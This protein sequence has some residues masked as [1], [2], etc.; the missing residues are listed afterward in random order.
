MININKVDIKKRSNM[1]KILQYKEL[2]LLMLPGILF[3]FI[4][5]YLPMFGLVIAFQDY[6]PS[7]GVNGIFSADF[8]GLKHFKVFFNSIYAK[9]IIS[10]TLIISFMKLVIGF[11]APIIL[12][13]MLNEVR[14]KHFK[15]I[16]QT[17]TYFPHF[18]SWVIVGGM[19]YA[20]L[21]TTSGVINNLIV[22]MGNEP[23]NFLSNP[24]TFRML[25]VISDTWK[26]IGWGSIIYLA[27]LAGISPELYE[28]AM[29]DGANKIQRLW[30]ITLP[31][32]TSTIIVVLILRLG[33]MMDIG[34]EQ[35]FMLYNPMVYKVGD[36][37]D[38]YV[39]R[40]GLINGRF[41]YAAA[42]GLFKSFVS[43]SAVLISDK[44][45]KK[46]GHDGII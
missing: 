33:K 45:A 29:I 36:I 22:S 43:L 46:V 12:A 15:K 44:L 17:V 35:I 4:F 27:A 30:Y 24:K 40:E 31:S 11:P 42:V 28:S 23:V 20:M 26:E 19:M 34:F 13:L 39:Y 7:Q 41:S 8:V 5:K 37:I 10:N 21:S 3:F 25:I 32:I 9:Q 38:T 14:H 16:I 2:Y 6:L 18:L 1:K